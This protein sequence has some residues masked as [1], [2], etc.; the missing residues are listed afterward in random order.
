MWQRLG[1]SLRNGGACLCA[2]G[3]VGGGDL[4]GIPGTGVNVP[5]PNLIL[6]V[7]IALFVVVALWLALRRPASG[8]PSEAALPPSSARSCPRPP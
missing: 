2:G 5:G 7:L 8:S 6:G 3:V 1:E 4:S